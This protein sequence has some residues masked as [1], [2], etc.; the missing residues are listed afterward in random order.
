MHDDFIEL[1]AVNSWLLERVTAQFP[2]GVRQYTMVEFNDPTVGPV[3]ITQSSKEFDEFFNSLVA[4]GGGDCPELAMQGLKLALENTPPNSFILVLTDASALDYLDTDLINHIYSLLTFSRS[5]V[6]FLITGLC[7]SINSPDFL[8]Y[9]DISAASFGHVF[10][11]SLSDLNKVFHYLDL[12]LSR[13]LNSS[14][15]LFSGEYTA[16][17]NYGIFAVEDNFTSLIITTDGV[18]YSIQ[19]LGPDSLEPPLEP[20]ISELW[21]SMYLLKNPGYGVWTIEIYAGSRCSLR[22]EGLTAVN[23]SSARDCSECH[24]YANC[25]E[26]FG[27]VECNCRDGFI[28]DGFTCSDEDE[29]AYSW[30]NNCSTGTCQNTFG[31]YICVCPSGFI[32]NLMGHCVDL[33]ECVSPELNSCHSSASCI[34]YYGAYSCACKDGYFGDGFHCEIDECKNGA[35]GLGTECTKSLGSYTCFDPCS[36]HTV[37]D[38][39]WRSTSNMHYSPINCDDSKYGWYRFIG[40]GGVRMPESCAPQYGCGTHAAMWLTDKHPML[41][42]G[43]VNRTACA[44]FGS[45]CFLSSSVQIRACPGGYHV[46]KLEGTPACFLSYCTDPSTSLNTSI[47]AADEEW[48]PKDGVY[49]CYCKDEYEVAALLDI[50]PELTCDVYDMRAVF[51]KCQLTSLDFNANSVTLNDA[52]CFGFRDDPSMNTFTVT[53]P[54]QAGACGLQIIINGTHVTYKST[55]QLLLESTGLITRDEE[56]TVTIYCVYLLD[57]MVSLNMAVNPFFSS[58]NITVGGTGQFTAYMALYKDSSYTTPY[59]GTEVVLSTKSM[60]YVGVF[61]QGGDAFDYVL[62]MRTCYATPSPNADDP[63]KYYIIQDSCPNKQDSTISVPENGV[64]KKGRLS[65]QVFKFVG[66]HDYVYIHCAV[67]LC[68]VTAGSCAPSCSGSRSRSSAAEKSYQLSLGPIRREDEVIVTP[69]SGSIGTHE[70]SALVGFVLLL[71]T[72]VWFC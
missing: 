29:C 70:S 47:C 49:G 39:P 56:L 53:S 41:S 32:D 14:V 58:T 24:S 63:L 9:R 8:I 67:S 23:I 16:G 66:N 17:Y 4:T 34:N 50:R 15:R 11:V 54:L 69:P 68:D 10:Q 48:K 61:V 1:K 65:V 52:S 38:E 18:I 12:T 59:E 35:C 64:S 22:V 42:D 71:M 20:I 37:L 40:N 28:G 72:Q 45:C 13:P 60:L 6:F 31:S 7:G 46:Y 5:Q 19:V 51:Q 3:R 62:V 43:I 57:M 36:D 55:M 26:Y 27:S 44:S 21:G 33:D 30:S 2:C 25:E